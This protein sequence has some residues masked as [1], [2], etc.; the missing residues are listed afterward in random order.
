[1]LENF[2]FVRLINE[3]LIGLEGEMN[4]NTIG[5]MLR[6]IIS[7]LTE[8]SPDVICDNEICDVVGF[9]HKNHKLYVSDNIDDDYN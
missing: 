5:D 2:I 7:S 3:R 8:H 1:M 6:D 9:I 4:M